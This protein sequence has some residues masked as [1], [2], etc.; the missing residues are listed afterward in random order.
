MNP[1][2]IGLLGILLL[3]VLMALRMWI[4]LALAFVGFLG[5]IFIQG[6]DRAMLV[7]STA[8]YT[9]IAKESF[10][11][12]P[13]FM[14]M[15]NI[16]SETGIGADLYKAA[17]A[18]IGQW[19]GGLA[20]ATTIASAMFAAIVGSATAGVIVFGKVAY[21]EMKKY[22]YD[23]ALSSGTIVASATMGILIPPSVGFIIYGILTEQ[24]VG[25]LFMAGIIPGLIQMFVYM[26]VIYV[27]CRLNP[28]KG[29]AGPKTTLKEK[30]VSIKYVWMML[31]LFLLVMGT[32]YTGVCTPTEAGA[33]GAFG[34][35]VI[36]FA[37][38]RLNLKGM[39]NALLDTG[40]LVGMMLMLLMA[41][42]I[43]SKFMA[44]SELPFWMGHTVSDLNMPKAAVMALITVMYIIA[45]TALPG[46]LVIILTV[47]IIYPV[48]VALGYDPIWFGVLMV[49]LVEIGDISPPEGMVVFL[50]NGISGVP[51]TTIFRGLFPFLGGDLIRI[52]LLM[53]FPQIALW[54]PS[55]M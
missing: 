13:M 23:D 32:I 36:T 34:A 20:M 22:K 38:K 41:T 31:A 55:L 12:L 54:L 30:L 15:G 50:M 24:P 25:K 2:F 17:H 33:I 26:G 27:I 14:L 37:S 6:A 3:L 39:K 10:T 35:I 51:V 43:F 52:I 21:P 16:I 18:W 4:G 28:K 29:P 9:F 48:A 45:G 7:V 44:V 47:P 19:R 40:I 8:P 11:V 46:M 53:A 1:E 42:G 49:I 5:L